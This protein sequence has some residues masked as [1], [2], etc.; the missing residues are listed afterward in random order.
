MRPS[1]QGLGP[2]TQPAWLGPENQ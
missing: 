2:E 1:L